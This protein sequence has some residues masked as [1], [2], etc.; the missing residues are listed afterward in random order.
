MKNSTI[1]VSLFFFFTFNSYS[2]ERKSTL[3]SIPIIG[4]YGSTSCWAASTQMLVNAYDKNLNTQCE[5]L[6]RDIIQCNQRGHDTCK[7]INYKII[8][9]A[10]EKP[11][12]FFLNNILRPNFKEFKIS[13]KMATTPYK[14]WSDSINHWTPKNKYSINRQDVFPWAALKQNFDGD[15]KSPMCFWKRFS[16]EVSKSHITVFCGYEHTK[17]DNQQ[18]KW[19]F[20]KDPYPIRKEGMIDGGGAKYLITYEFYKK[21]VEN[22]LEYDD[23]LNSVIYGFKY[24]DSTKIPAYAKADT[25]L[26]SEIKNNKYYN[27]V[28]NTDRNPLET[29]KNQAKKV[30]TNLKAIGSDSLLNYIGLQKDS[31]FVDGTEILKLIDIDFNDF[32]VIND[33]LSY[34]DS[35]LERIND[36]FNLTPSLLTIFDAKCT[37]LVPAKKKDSTLSIMAFEETKKKQWYTTR[38]EIFPQSIFSIVKR[39]FPIK[40]INAVYLN[41]DYGLTNDFLIIEPKI[42]LK[43]PLILIDL[44]GTMKDFKNPYDS[45]NM[46]AYEAKAHKLVGEKAHLMKQ[47]LSPYSKSCEANCKYKITEAGKAFIKSYQDLVQNSNTISCITTPSIRCKRF[48]APSSDFHFIDSLSQISF[49]SFF[50]NDYIE[51]PEGNNVF[52]T[53]LIGNFWIRD[54]LGRKMYKRVVQIFGSC[55]ECNP[56]SAFSPKSQTPDKTNRFDDDSFQQVIFVPIAKYKAL[57]NRHYDIT[58]FERLKSLALSPLDMKQINDPFIESEKGYLANSNVKD[59]NNY[60]D[61][62]S[63]TGIVSEVILKNGNKIQCYILNGQSFTNSNGYLDWKSEI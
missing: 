9:L 46:G 6:R 7:C 11:F 49:T 52:R 34:G 21:D 50:R 33:S 13:T 51:N 53:P 61:I 15:K 58:D 26:N 5:L 1:I 62:L 20:V 10:A 45:V 30:L 16:D 40:N 44:N 60:R 38:I 41:R 17:Y 47:Y 48:L 12:W 29:V 27:I 54:N 19:I 32:I 35:T 59:S 24:S 25:I 63:I 23:P 28:T 4:Q 8:S 36:I 31:V 39:F 43:K 37:Y 14:R 55:T 42:K 22:S 2:Q 56:D 3:L 18:M 57:N